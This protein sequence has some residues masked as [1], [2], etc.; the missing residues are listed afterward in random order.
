[1]GCL[2]STDYLPCSQLKLSVSKRGAIVT[3]LSGDPVVVELN[4]K[5]VTF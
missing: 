4:G 5:Q 2:R 3:L 1:M